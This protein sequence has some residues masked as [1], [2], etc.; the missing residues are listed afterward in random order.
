MN[1]NL[2][3]TTTT[4]TATTET[5][6]CEAKGKLVENELS[7]AEHTLRQLS[8]LLDALALSRNVLDPQRE[9]IQLSAQLE[10]L[11]ETLKRAISSDYVITVDLRKSLRD[12][13]NMLSWVREYQAT[14]LALC[15]QLDKAITATIAL[16]TLVSEQVEL[17]KLISE[18][19]DEMKGW[20]IDQLKAF[21]AL[22]QTLHKG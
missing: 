11:D 3:C 19:S 12:V 2:K 14:R 15:T 20:S 10:E 6:L 18:I 21:D 22:V 5:E 17:E 7:K 16:I 9:D 1:K 8:K 4:A 13:K